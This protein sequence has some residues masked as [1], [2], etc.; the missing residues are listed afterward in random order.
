MH[1]LHR[2]SSNTRMGEA[3]EQDTGPVFYSA[4][5]SHGLHA[6]RFKGSDATALPSP[7]PS[8]CLS[9]ALLLSIPLW[10]AIWAIVSAITLAWS[11]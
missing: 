8:P 5:G 10:G 1:G 9:W 3:N 11:S 4:S 6:G 2:A 7:G